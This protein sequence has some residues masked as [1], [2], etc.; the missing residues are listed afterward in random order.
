MPHKMGEAGGGI[1]PPV[2]QLHGSLA[3]KPGS[4]SAPSVAQIVGRPGKA[5][6]VL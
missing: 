1:K 4:Y 3:L 6:G 5:K 2:T